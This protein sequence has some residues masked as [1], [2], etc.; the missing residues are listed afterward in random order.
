MMS[1]DFGFSGRWKKW[2]MYLRLNPGSG[3]LTRIL[4]RYM[5]SLVQGRCSLPPQC[6]LSS[7][8]MAL[9]ISVLFQ[10]TKTSHTLFSCNPANLHHHREPPRPSTTCP[11]LHSIIASRNPTSSPSLCAST[12]LAQA[13]VSPTQSHSPFARRASLS[14]GS[15]SRLSRLTSFCLLCFLLCFVFFWV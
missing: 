15:P 6:K 3:V 9:F 8:P 7:Q 14:P 2:D 1:T 13:L 10:T 4:K 11:T 5:H 12:L